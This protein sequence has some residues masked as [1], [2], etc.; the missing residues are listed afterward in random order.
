MQLPRIQF[1]IR[2]LMVAIAIAAVLIAMPGGLRV[3]AAAVSL[4]CLAIYAARRIAMGGHRALAAI[5]FWGLAIPV[6]CL[7]AACCTSPG[8]FSWGLFL[9]WIPL[10][11]PTLAGFGA[12]WAALEARRGGGHC[13]SCRTARALVFAL[14]VMPGVTS[15]TV[16]PFRLRFL[17][18]RSALDRVADQLGAGRAVPFPR[19]AG[20]FRLAAS[21]VDPQSRGVALLIDPDPNGPSGFVRHENPLAGPYGCFRPIRGDWWHLGLGGGWC[22]HE[23]D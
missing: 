2:R 4:P 6:N 18:A 1:T 20:P 17:A 12:T 10:I 21:R 3:F 22:Y 15:W 9:L 13:P 14:A 16:W 23:E 11:V 5:A 19:D 7:Y 8:M